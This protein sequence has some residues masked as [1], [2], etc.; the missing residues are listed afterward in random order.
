MA[1]DPTKEIA[2]QWGKEWSESP[3]SEINPRGYCEKYKVSVFD[4]LLKHLPPEAKVLEIGCGNSAWLRL[5]R[6]RYPKISLYG[7]DFSDEAVAISLRHKI[8]V[9]KGDAR[10]MPYPDD[11]FDLVFSFGTVEHFPETELAIWE[12][13][14]V[15]K[16]GGL[17]WIET[18]NRLSLQGLQAAFSNYR[19]DRDPYD[20]MIAQGKWYTHWDLKRMIRYAPGKKKIYI[21]GSGPVLPFSDILPAWLDNLFSSILPRRYVGG[22]AGI[23]VRKL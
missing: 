8:N 14:R 7:L 3:D 15:V 4:R 9:A 19:H 11:T 12:H 1:F 10:H 16:P 5:L 22:N 6:S 17:I 18:P 20:L 21:Q 13:F 2:E 23:V